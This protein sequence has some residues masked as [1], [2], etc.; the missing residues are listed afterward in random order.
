MPD[1]PLDTIDDALQNPE[2]TEA[3]RAH[4]NSEFS[5]ENLEFHERVA[6]FKKDAQNPAISDDQLRADARQITND[7]IRPGADKQV[8]VSSTQVDAVNKA[9]TGI[10]G[11]SRAQIGKILDESQTEVTKLMSR[12]GLP[13]F[14]RTEAYKTAKAEVNAGLDASENLQR[15]EARERQLKLNP[16]MGDKAKAMV[17]SG[18]MVSMIRDV[19]RQKEA[20]QQQVQD[21]AGRIDRAIAASRAFVAPP[22]PSLPQ[23]VV[24]PP[25]VAPLDLEAGVEGRSRSNGLSDAAPPKPSVRETLGGKDASKVAQGKSVSVSASDGEPSKQSV[26]DKIK[27]FEKGGAA[28]PAAKRGVS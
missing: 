13:R 25:S 8:N 23:A 4:L 24:Q 3:F 16:S 12:D 1:R 27:L 7:Y 11:A 15:L 22:P 19:E 5:G 2:L 21:R 14:Q 10:N 26:K 28:P 6:Q 9:M 17:T 18:G 20:A